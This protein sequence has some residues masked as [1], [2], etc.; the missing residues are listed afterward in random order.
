MLESR[1]RT[2]L[3]HRPVDSLRLAA[4]AVTLFCAFVLLG[5]CTARQLDAG[6]YNA[7]QSRA[8]MKQTGMPACDGQKPFGDYRRDRRHDLA[9]Q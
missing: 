6:V 4:G 1:R 7:L 2:R 8:C 3:G 9:E 5:G